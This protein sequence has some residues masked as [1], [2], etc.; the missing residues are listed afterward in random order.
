MKKNIFIVS[1]FLLLSV[2]SSAWAQSAPNN[3][4][5]VYYFHTT[6]RCPTCYKIEQYTQEAVNKYFD[7]EI[8]SGTISFKAVNVQ[9]EKNQHYVKD[10][11]LFAKAV[12][13]SMIKEGKEVKFNNL[14][15]I[16][17]YVRDKEK[18]Y[19][20]IKTETNQYLEEV[21]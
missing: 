6:L 3:Y 20:Y 2:F 19:N 18:F 8:K 5:V 21:K 4:I 13:I 11:Q 1:C 16:W 9:Q 14:T 15:K 7:K 10:Y 17:E 12:V